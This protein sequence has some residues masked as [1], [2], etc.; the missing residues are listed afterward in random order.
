MPHGLSKQHRQGPA[1]FQQQTQ[2]RNHVREVWVAAP[3][4]NMPHIC[5]WRYGQVYFC[6]TPK[7]L[8]LSFLR[9][10]T[11]NHHIQS[12][13][14]HLLQFVPTQFSAQHLEKACKHLLPSASRKC[15]KASIFTRVKLSCYVTAETKSNQQF[16][17]KIQEKKSYK[18]ESL[19]LSHF[20]DSY[21][22]LPISGFSFWTLQLSFLSVFPFEFFLLI[23]HCA[24]GFL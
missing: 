16:I 2:R 6:C 9:L 24:Y 3:R 19:P 10:S 15:P 14:Q 21:L 8:W 13:L 22:L 18:G 5:T 7:N 17:E 4:L 1:P 23:Q 20:T 12:F 11:G